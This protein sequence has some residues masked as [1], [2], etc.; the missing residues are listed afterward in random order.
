MPTTKDIPDATSINFIVRPFNTTF[1]S[2]TGEMETFNPA[3]LKTDAIAQFDVERRFFRNTFKYTSDAI[4]ITDY[5]KVDEADPTDIRFY[6]NNYLLDNI[7]LPTSKTTTSLI[8]AEGEINTSY[9]NTGYNYLSLLSRAIV[10]DNPIAKKTASNESYT[11][12]QMTVDYDY[13]RY[14]SF[15][16]FNTPLGVDLFS[17]E[18]DLR[19]NISDYTFETDANAENVVTSKIQEILQYCINGSSDDPLPSSES[20]LE[21]R[22]YNK[23]TGM[24]SG[25]SIT[26]DNDY[27]LPRL[28][29]MQIAKSDPKRFKYN[30]SYL[31]K[32]SIPFEVGD[33]ISFKVT[34]QAADNQHLLTELESAIEPRSYEIKI[35]IVADNENTLPLLLEDGDEYTILYDYDDDRLISKAVRLSNID[36]V[37]D[38]VGTRVRTTGVYPMGSGDFINSRISFNNVTSIENVKYYNSGV[39]IVDEVP[40]V[41]IDSDGLLIYNSSIDSVPDVSPPAILR[42]DSDADIEIRLTANLA[43]EGGGDGTATIK[44]KDLSMTSP[45]LP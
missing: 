42:I 14:L 16:L 37:L 30:K 45:P 38:N 41:T 11:D 8:T 29:F 35:N 40:P 26:N 32:E 23:D 20:Y 34:L 10:T 19:R 2:L 36:H 33:S 18:M 27:N 31:V 43:L 4:D 22:P 15:K 44:L 39:E 9:N 7:I 3:E 24:I 25:D 21:N 17:N 5:I 28:L 12:D 6:T 13:I 1:T